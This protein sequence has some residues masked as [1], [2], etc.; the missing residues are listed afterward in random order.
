[1]TRRS[2]F[3]NRERY[4]AEVAIRQLQLKEKIRSV[5]AFSI[6]GAKARK[7]AAAIAERDAALKSL[8]ET[9]AEQNTQIE[10]LRK[11]L[12]EAKFQSGILEQSY[13]KQLAEARDRANNAEKSV[14]DSQSRISELEVSE[15][16]LRSE[17][18]DAKSRLDMFGPEA[19]S[20][21]E[22]LESFSQPKDQPT[23]HEMAAEVDPVDDPQPVE[24][25]LAPDLM[26]TANRKKS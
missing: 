22:M 3:G 20:I 9:V 25:M 6:A 23:R 24:E 15:K 13:A 21:D 19:G 2:V 8:E 1:M 16:A 12:D 18:G 14:D 10:E 7:L 5:Q 11:L 17:L 26:L 4:A